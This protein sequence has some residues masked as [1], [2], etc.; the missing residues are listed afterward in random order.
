MDIQQLLNSLTERF[1]S[2]ASVKNVYGAPVVAGNRTII[3]AAEVRYAL[4]GGGGHSQENAASEGGGGGGAVSARP[5]GALEVTS[6]GTRFIVFNDKR[7]MAAA[8]AIGF[9]LGA[10]LAALTRTR[11]IEVVKRSE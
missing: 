8:L 9:A 3:P 1:S 10:A 4:G 6:E 5:I 11:R 2:S 7:R